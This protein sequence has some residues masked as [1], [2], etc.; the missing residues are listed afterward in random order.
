MTPPEFK[1][2]RVPRIPP[3]F[4]GRHNLIWLGAVLFGLVWCSVWAY[5]DATRHQTI[6]LV[7]Q[8]AA[9]ALNV[10]NA[11]IFVMRW[12]GFWR[13]WNVDRAHMLKAIATTQAE[14]E[15]ILRE[16]AEKE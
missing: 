2:P 6:S 15:R 16:H 4:F 1:P 8:S 5:I 11:G 12:A 7:F 9:L 3:G 10:M 14:V 13:K